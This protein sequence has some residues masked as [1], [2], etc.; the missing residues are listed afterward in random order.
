MDMD[1]Q[2]FNERLLKLFL[3]MKKLENTFPKD[4]KDGYTPQKDIDYRDG[5]NGKDGRDGVDGYTPIKGI[6]Y[7]DGTDGK[8][9]ADGYTPIKG[10]D[11]FDG[12]DGKDGKPGPA[13]PP[14]RSGSGAPGMSAY[15]TAKLGGYTGTFEEFYTALANGGTVN[16]VSLG[17]TDTTAYRGDRGKTAYDHSQSAHAPSDAE[18]NVNADWNAVSGDAQ[19]LNKPTIPTQTSQLTNNS[20]FISDASYVH[21][22]NN[23][24]TTEKNKLAGIAENANKYT[25]P[26]NH[27]PSIITQDASNRFVTDT[28]KT[29]WNAKRDAITRSKVKIIEEEFLTANANV[30]DDMIGA[31]VSSGT[32]AAVSGYANHPGIVSISDSTTSNGAYYIMTETNALLLAG[33]EKATFV[34]QDR[35][36][37]VATATTR[38]GFFDS[39]AIQTAPTDGVW[40]EIVGGVLT[41]KCKNNSGP[42]NTGT[43]YTLT[44][45]TWYTLTIEL[46]SDASLATF[47]IYSEAGNQ[48]WQQSVNANIPTATG[49]ETGFGIIAGE[50]TTSAA[51]VICYIDYMSLEITRTITR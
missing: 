18:K 16:G 21:T 51:A 11:Y 27:S 20:N 23:Y 8:D 2:K 40:A 26:A 17:E 7:F 9:G 32:L 43:T 13:G 1:E 29:T 41:G 39:R 46:N 5:I 33:G 24:T 12:K 45:S 10:I 38:M 3:R 37:S 44:G 22:D 36:S 6:D 28:E 50:T 42:T 30:V 35:S 4:G 49:R 48:L 19:I 31:A 25:H 14:G 47:T 34:F 15:A